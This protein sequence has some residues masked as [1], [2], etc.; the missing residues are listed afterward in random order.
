[1]ALHLARVAEIA[2]ELRASACVFGAPT[3]RDPGELQ[4]ATAQ[5]IAVDFFGKLAEVFASRGLVLCFEANP[6][7]YNC[8][9][10]TGTPEALG[11]VETIDHPGLALQLDTGTIFANGEDAEIITKGAERIGHCHVSEPSLVPIGTSGLDHT[12]VAAAL[13]A[14]KYR[15]W[16]SIEMKAGSNWK[17]ALVQAHKFV[18]RSYF[19]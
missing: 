17:T 19:N 10:I 2:S 14:S 9:F 16:I 1:M 11:L 8:R 5:R 12:P 4:P 15:G 3:L 7:L 6:S 13:R 18:V